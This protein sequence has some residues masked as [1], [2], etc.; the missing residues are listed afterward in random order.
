LLSEIIIERAFRHAGRAQQAV[1]P[2][3]R[4][5]L[6]GQRRDTGADQMVARLRVVVWCA[7]RAA[8]PTGSV[9]WRP[10]GIIRPIVY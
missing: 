3:G 1:Q 10:W 6:F 9:R 4:E 8:A 7:G 5:A 2:G